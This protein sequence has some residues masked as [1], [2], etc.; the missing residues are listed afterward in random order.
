MVVEEETRNAA[1]TD[2]APST[3]RA[4]ILLPCRNERERIGDCLQS[5]LDQELPTGGALEILVLDGQSEDGTEEVVRSMAAQDER[6]R[7]LE[8]ER[9]LKVLGLNR[10]V[11]EAT[12]DYV[13]VLDAHTKYAADYLAQCVATAERT[14]ADVV[15][16]VMETRTGG[17]AYG[18]A[19]V[20]ALTTH[21][22]G[23][24]GSGFRTGSREGPVDTVPFAL[25]R[26]D[27]FDRV[28]LFDE[29]LVRAQDYEFNRRVRTAGGTVWLN[30]D[31]RSM[32][33]N[34][35]SLIAFL[36]KQLCWEAPY[37]AYL[38]YLAPHAF[39]A[40]HAV[41][42]CFALGVMSGLL[43]APFYPWILSAF[44]GVLALYA[45]LALVAAGQQATRFRE[46]RHVFFLPLAFFLF[47]FLHG[48][49]ILCGVLR[50][51]TGTAPVQHV[52]EPWPG[53]GRRLTWPI[54]KA[55]DID[56]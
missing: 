2:M 43:L 40:R 45:A 13:L 35:S 28:G 49:G 18:A 9:R 22:F 47:H 19:L 52:K 27:V 41:T 48:L 46:P 3:W 26:R 55:D 10:G 38:W 29:R 44:L 15:G 24:G 42:L 50:L 4:T 25:F 36:K 7:L 6:M 33:Y 53:A 32:Y 23:V 1:V 39:S 30:P 16:G 17:P 51:M 34:Q 8:N 20:Q 11:E 31:I 37:N 21:R 56:G 14:E 54:P 12:G 5:L